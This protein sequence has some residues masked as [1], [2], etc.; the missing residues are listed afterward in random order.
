MKCKYRR[1]TKEEKK[2]I[3]INYYKTSNG[4]EMKKRLQR[5]FICGILLIMYSFIEIYEY[6]FINTHTYILLSIILFFISGII[7][8]VGFIRI[9]LKVLNQYAIKN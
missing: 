7:F 5:I 8:L 9:R 6:I 4:I 3:R 2:K 1:M